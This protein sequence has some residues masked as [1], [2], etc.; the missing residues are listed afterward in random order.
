MNEAPERIWFD[1][2]MRLDHQAPILY[3][4]DR[5]DDD[6]EYI[7][8]DLARLPAVPRKEWLIAMGKARDSALQCRD[9][10][11]EGAASDPMLMVYLALRDILAWHEGGQP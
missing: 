1:R 5:E 11:V 10:G 6:I 7:R 2:N 4:S 9:D 8:A 3:Q